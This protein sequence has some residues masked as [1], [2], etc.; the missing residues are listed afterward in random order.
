MG[1]TMPR[2]PPVHGGGLRYHVMAHGND[3]QKIFLGEVTFGASSKR[4]GPC[5]SVTLCLCG[6]YESKSSPLNFPSAYSHDQ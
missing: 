6:H 5:A 3:G 2:H 1:K 4:F